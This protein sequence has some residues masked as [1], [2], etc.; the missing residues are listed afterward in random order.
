M[1]ASIFYY[2]VFCLLSMVLDLSDIQKVQWLEG[3]S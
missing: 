1:I 3:K 2:L